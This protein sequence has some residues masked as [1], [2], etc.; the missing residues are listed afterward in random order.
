MRV[1]IDVGGTNT[2]AVLMSGRQVLAATKAPTSRDVVAGVVAAVRAILN[3]SGI[4]GDRITGVMIGTT[5][6]TNALVQG[7]SLE[8]VGVL[9]I[10]EPAG[11]CLPPFVGWP[12][13]LRGIIRG[14]VAGLRG[15]YNVD[16]R[17]IAAFDD[18]AAHA[19]IAGFAADGIRSVAIS[20]IFSPLRDDM[21]RRCAALVEQIIPG[22]SVS[23]SSE[24]GR[25]GFLEREN[26]T[27]LNA[28][29]RALSVSVT[30]AFREALRELGIAAPFYVSQ[31]DGTPL[32]IGQVERFPVFTVASGPTNSMRGASFLTGREDAIVV[33]IG[34]TTSDVGAIKAGFP[35]ESA[36]SVD[37]G[38]VKTNFRMPDVLAIGVGGG[39]RVRR[40]SD[41]PAG[42]SIG[43]TVSIGPDSVG[44]E[45]STRALVFGGEDMTLTDL[46]VAD[47]RLDVGDAGR[48]AH[49]D[50]DFIAAG[51][52]EF[53]L[54]IEDAVERVKTAPDPVPVIL[55]GGGGVIFRGGIKG[56]SEILMP[57][58]AAVANAIG[59][60]IAQIGGEYE[61]VCSYDDEGREAA[62]AAV[63]SEACKRARDAGAEGDLDVLEI[64]EVPL[65]YLPG[66]TVRVRVKVVSRRDD[67]VAEA[68]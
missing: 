47:G 6:F 27:I 34:G 59:A 29:L 26:A 39:S 53:R 54:R 4:A 35:R 50:R 31:N 28:A 42:C 63:R 21:E 49:L 8:R 56:A 44:Y 16:G 17:P 57:A 61:K 15:G 3:E 58:N 60:A 51:L 13:A 14:G 20:C 32:D 48:V 33:D 45:L 65:S 10:A 23:L 19:A 41:T 37:I 9:R 36:V 24:I 12:N 30:Q 40:A 1:G 66:R 64:E 5:H 7:L 38:G 68:V 11:C 22:A 43:G 52:E 46:A 67:R 2:D 55:V 62:I 25:I 18:D